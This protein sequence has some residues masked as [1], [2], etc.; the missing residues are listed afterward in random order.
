MKHDGTIKHFSYV[1]LSNNVSMCMEK[2]KN[3]FVNSTN[4]FVRLD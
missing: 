4:G 3:V 2:L 1:S